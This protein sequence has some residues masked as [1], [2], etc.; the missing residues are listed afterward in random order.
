MKK[1]R[2]DAARKA[3]QK[4]DAY[5][6][7]GGAHQVRSTKTQ[8]RDYGENNLKPARKRHGVATSSTSS[9]Q[10]DRSNPNYEGKMQTQARTQKGGK[11]TST[12]VSWDQR[13]PMKVPGGGHLPSPTASQTTVD[14]K[15]KN[16]KRKK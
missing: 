6:A 8:S 5:S 3:L 14:G 1:A 7:S 4:P 12:A 10:T 9:R 15:T 13:H 11:N 16:W 2:E